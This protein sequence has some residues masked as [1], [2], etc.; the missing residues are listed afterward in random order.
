MDNNS[1]VMCMVTSILDIYKG[2][3]TFIC[4]LSFVIIF[5]EKITIICMYKYNE[6]KILKVKM[7]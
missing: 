2:C 7:A 4:Q 5:Y 6:V 1:L 3:N